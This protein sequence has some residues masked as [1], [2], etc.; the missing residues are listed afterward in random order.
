[1]QRYIGAISVHFF[2]SVNERKAEL[3]NSCFRC[4]K[5]GHRSD[6]CKQMKRCIYCGEQNSHHRSLCPHKF[7]TKSTVLYTTNE[8]TAEQEQ[9]AQQ[10]ESGLFTTSTS[11]ETKQDTCSQQN[12]SA[13]L[14]QNKAKLNNVHIK[15]HC[16][17]QTGMCLR[18][19]TKHI[20]ST[21]H[22]L[23]CVKTRNVHAARTAHSTREMH[24]T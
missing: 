7:K 1:M 10:K 23:K 24:S 6:E 22:Q 19:H 4:L 2:R 20:V 18:T 21:G 17:Q 8:C 14:S 12:E 15:V 9:C 11:Y 13:L 3:K 5:E 16:S